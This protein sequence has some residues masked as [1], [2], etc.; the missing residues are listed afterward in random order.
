MAYSSRK[1]VYAGPLR[2]SKRYKSGS[3]S[4]NRYRRSY[5]QR[6]GNRS[7]NAT[8][9]TNGLRGGGLS[10]RSRKVSS[11]MWKKKLWDS[12]LQTDHFRSAQSTAVVLNTPAN[13]AQGQWFFSRC[14]NPSFYLPAGGAY[15]PV[16]GFAD[17]TRTLTIRG[18][19]V[20]IRGFNNSVD[21]CL[22]KLFLMRTIL[23][24]SL[25][26]SSVQPVAWDPTMD[27]SFRKDFKIYKQWSF[28]IGVQESFS[29]EHRLG[30]SKYDTSIGPNQYVWNWGIHLVNMRSNASVPFELLFGHN[31]SFSGDLVVE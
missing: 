19:R 4:K 30:I 31:I 7:R 17:F 9:V 5:R 28:A 27:P 12:T 11:R 24:G 1:R 16:T 25:P 22:V 8:M 21:A 10:Y 18:G 2:S 13:R 6:Y 26:P 15:P 3:Y 23:G 20:T 14:F 29:V